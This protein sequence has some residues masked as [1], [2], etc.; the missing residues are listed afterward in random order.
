MEW[1]TRKEKIT[2]RLYEVLNLIL[3]MFQSVGDTV[4]VSRT[5]RSLIHKYCPFDNSICTQCNAT[6]EN[7]FDLGEVNYSKM[8]EMIIKQADNWEWNQNHSGR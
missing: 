1:Q 6:N 8:V 4:F 5:F 7:I 2:E 3:A